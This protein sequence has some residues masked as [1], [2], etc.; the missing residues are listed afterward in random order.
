MKDLNYVANEINKGKNL[1]MN[2]P[3]FANS[4][5]SLYNGLAYIKMSM[6]YYTFYE[7]LKEKEYQNSAL[8]DVKE[9]V[10][11]LNA[12]IQKEVIDHGNMEATKESTQEA[13]QYQ[14]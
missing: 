8:T 7:T 9:Y 13:S 1:E 5:M 2:L 4:M 11:R 14:K 3:K 10:D 12:I 6:N